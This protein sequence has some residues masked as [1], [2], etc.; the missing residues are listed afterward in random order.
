MVFQDLDDPPVAATF[1]EMMCSIYQS[2]GSTGLIT[3][4][5][6]RDF[7]QVRELNYPVFSSSAICG[8]GF[9]Q[10]LDLGKPVRVGGL[11]LKQGELLHGDCNGVTRI[12]IEIADAAAELAGE[13]V[14]AESIV[15]DYAKGPGEKTMAGLVAARAELHEA[16]VALKQKA[17]AAR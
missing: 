14:A 13:F 9:W 10:L 15:T 1:G 6:G 8:A 11:A 3:S 17:L 16:L 12:P 7:E 4:G 2:F 5:A